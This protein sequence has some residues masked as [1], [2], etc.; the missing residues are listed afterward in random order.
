VKRL[1]LWPIAAY[2]R[3]ISP[4]LP[5]RCKYYPTCSNYAAQAV[6]ELGPVR[7]SIVAAWRLLRCNPLSDGGIDDLADRRLFRSADTAHP[8]CAHP[9]QP[10][11]AKPEELSVY[12]EA[13]QSAGHVAEEMQV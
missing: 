5:Q 4:A 9:R 2:Q 3:W 10:R 11:R 6:K 13:E 12:G 7:G 1:L 8:D